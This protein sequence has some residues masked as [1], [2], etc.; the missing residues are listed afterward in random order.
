MAGVI[1]SHPVVGDIHLRLP[2]TSVE[3]TYNMNTQTFD[4]YAGQVVQLLSINFDQFVIS[5][6]FGKEGPWGRRIENRQLVDRDI[7]EFDDYKTTE[8]YAIGLAQMTAY[9]RN[10]FSIASQGNNSHLQGNYNQTPV[11]LTYQ[12]ALDV[13]IDTGKAETWLI[14]PT[15]FPSYRRSN[16]DFA[17]EWQ[18]HAE[19]YEP[20]TD[21]QYQTSLAAIDRLRNAVGYKPLSAF[22]DPVGQFLPANFDNLTAKQ[23]LAS[24]KKAYGKVSSSLDSTFAHYAAM[25]PAYTSDDLA[26]LLNMNGS[27]PLAGK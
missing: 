11:S 24:L 15:S 1:F 7:T 14:Y 12:G 20:A 4:T 26:A 23:K 21:I 10:Y 27:F 5:G 17:P 13:P 9:F 22:S 19:V 25:L 3:W 18:V 6:K 2:P 8:P 16:Q